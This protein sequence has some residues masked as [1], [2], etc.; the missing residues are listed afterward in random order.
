MVL[1][2]V[3]STLLS[4]SLSASATDERD[5]AALGE[6]ILPTTARVG[7][8][9]PKLYLETY[10]CDICCFQPSLYPLVRWEVVFFL[11]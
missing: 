8:V 5:D 6:H 3:V 7:D 10:K 2:A 4:R 11:P 1:L 9:G